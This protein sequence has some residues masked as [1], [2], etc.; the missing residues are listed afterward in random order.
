LIDVSC[1]D[2]FFFRADY[3]GNPIERRKDESSSSFSDRTQL[4]PHD[5]SASRTRGAGGGDGTVARSRAS[6][7]GTQSQK[8]ASGSGSAF[9]ETFS[10]LEEDSE[11]G[12]DFNTLDLEDVDP[13]TAEKLIEQLE[14]KQREDEDGAG[15]FSSVRRSGNENNNNGFEFLDSL[16]AD[17]DYSN[18]LG[19]NELATR[20]SSTTKTGFVGA[21]AAVAG[22]GSPSTTGAATG[23]DGVR[24]LQ[25]N[26]ARN[27]GSRTIP[28]A[29]TGGNA[30]HQAAEAAGAG[31]DPW[32]EDYADEEQNN[33][34]EEQD[35]DYSA[36]EDAAIV[37]R[38]EGVGDASLRQSNTAGAKKTA[39][40]ATAQGTAASSRSG[41]TTSTRTTPSSTAGSRSGVQ[42][43]QQGLGKLV[44]SGSG[45]GAGAQQQQAQQK[46]AK[47]TS[48]TA[49]TAG[50]KA[51]SA[52]ASITSSPTKQQGS[53]SAGKNTTIASSTKSN[54]TTGV[55]G[56]LKKMN[57][58][59]ASSVA[60]EARNRRAGSA[61]G[62][63]P[64][65]G[66]EEPPEN[67]IESVKVGA[68]KPGEK[69]SVLPIAPK[70]TAEAMI[71]SQKLDDDEGSYNNEDG[72]SAREKTLPAA[73]VGDDAEEMEKVDAV[74]SSTKSPPAS[75]GNKSSS[76]KTPNASSPKKAGTSPSPVKS[77]TSSKS[78]SSSGKKPIKG[79]R[80]SL[81]SDLP[82]VRLKKRS[83]PY[84]EEDHQVGEGNQRRKRIVPN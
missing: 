19:F 74:K 40:G 38:I 42:K 35:L 45:A 20:D 43:Q 65:H 84:G 16:D 54:T 34:S 78:S 63:L 71:R 31:T 58:T 10:S 62:V 25:P 59:S 64:G 47:T 81:R 5:S 66:G 53:A 82:V 8:P 56:A 30:K 77:P 4:H 2:F 12:S 15:A 21:A 18:G 41:A 67:R 75:S 9:S 55:G 36:G 73:G 83:Q 69:P 14:I 37:P 68:N 72:A 52:S 11:L 23:K 61:G 60:G 33:E 27:K 6:G 70:N 57:A 48:S 7:A 13:F 51:K 50:N 44:A 32:N 46:S 28:R 79:M 39:V 22:K 17:N 49:S 26:D 1:L 29:G 24:V 76:E 3:E 80:R